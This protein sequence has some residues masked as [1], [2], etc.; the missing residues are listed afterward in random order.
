MTGLLVL[1]GSNGDVA[2]TNDQQRTRLTD[3]KQAVENTVRDA[4]LSY[5]VRVAST[6]LTIRPRRNWLV[7][8]LQMKFAPSESVGVT[9]GRSHC[10]V[11][12][13]DLPS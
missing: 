3:V 13:Q 10:S 5:R 7:D 8:A 1:R 2:R 9:S 11:A 6:D 12:D 4:Y